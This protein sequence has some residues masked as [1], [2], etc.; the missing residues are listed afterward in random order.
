MQNVIS[1]VK[2]PA[3]NYGVV[4]YHWRISFSNTCRSMTDNIS[5]PR[6]GFR[7]FFVSPCSEAF[8]FV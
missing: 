6:S 2:R 7:S 8:L 1:A 3:L 5:P 4:E